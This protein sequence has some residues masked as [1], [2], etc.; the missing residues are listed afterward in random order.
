[1]FRRILKGA[2]REVKSKV[3]LA[4]VR[5]NLEFVGLGQTSA[6]IRKENWY[7]TK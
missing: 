7:G 3:Y 5:P 2:S 6:A 1:M 4:Y